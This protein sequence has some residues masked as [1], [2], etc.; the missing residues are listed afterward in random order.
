V[1]CD[2]GVGMALPEEGILEENFT[3]PEVGA[4]MVDYD[5]LTLAGLEIHGELVGGFIGG[6]F[7]FSGE[8]EDKALED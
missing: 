3:N 2:A 4:A 8:I 5:L 6:G 7:G 1:G